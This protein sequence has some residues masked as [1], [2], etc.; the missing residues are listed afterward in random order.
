MER[1]AVYTQTRSTHRGLAL[2]RFFKAADGFQFAPCAR[3]SPLPLN[4]SEPRVIAF[5][6]YHLLLGLFLATRHLLLAAALSHS[7]R[8]P[9]RHLDSFPPIDQCPSKPF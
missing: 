1:A 2:G 6:F 7:H 9:Q 8:R 5:T 4:I 3:L